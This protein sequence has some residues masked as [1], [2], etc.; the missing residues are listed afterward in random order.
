MI[1]RFSKIVILSYYHFFKSKIK[2][3]YNF[4]LLDLKLYLRQQRWPRYDVKTLKEEGEHICLKIEDL[5]FYWPK[6]FNTHGLSWL[7]NEIFCD[8]KC[9]PASYSHKKAI[10]PQGGWALDIG[11]CE[12]FFTKFAFQNGAENVVAI[13]PVSIVHDALLS[14]FINEYERHR[15]S[16]INAGVGK[17]KGSFYVNISENSVWDAHLVND[18]DNATLEKVEIITIDEIISSKKLKGPGFIKMDIEGAEMDA[19]EGARNTL[20]TFKPSL[21]I[22]VYHGYSNGNECARIIR[23]A[24]PDYNIEFRG[25]YLWELPARPFMLFAW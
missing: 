3:D 15:F 18:N 6:K 5:E 11:A 21:A 9:N 2:G 7:F 10:I 8:P 25:M 14:T 1:L 20:K 12:G 13:E 19:L 16:V 24:R 17:E 23:N 22:A 4:K